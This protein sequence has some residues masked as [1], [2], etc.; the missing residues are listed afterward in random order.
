MTGI[1]YEKICTVRRAVSAEIG[2][3]KGRVAWAVTRPGE[4]WLRGLEPPT[5]RS[6]VYEHTVISADKHGSYGTAN[7]RLT[8]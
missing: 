8:S 7:S 5:S 3:K 6:T 4:G 1:G 2:T